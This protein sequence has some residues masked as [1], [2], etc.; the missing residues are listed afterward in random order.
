MGGI[1]YLN[2]ITGNTEQISELALLLYY[3][4]N[5]NYNY[6]GK[7]QDLIDN[8]NIPRNE[9]NVP[10]LDQMQNTNELLLGPQ[11]LKLDC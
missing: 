2:L 10:N 8:T 4:Y 5:Y 1:C 6:I 11:L 7:I 9:V 3:T